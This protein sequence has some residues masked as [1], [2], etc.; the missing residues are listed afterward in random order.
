MALLVA[1]S[2]AELAQGVAHP[3]FGPSLWLSLRT[4][5]L[6]LA[7]V[8]VCGTPLAWWLASAQGWPQ[9]LADALVELPIVM[10]PAVVGIGL[11]ET[12]GRSGLLGGPLE[13]LGIQ[14][15]FATPAVILA[16]VTVSAPFYVQAAAAAF[17]RVDPDLLLVARTLGQSPV[18]AFARVAIPIAM[19]GLVSGGALAWA[20]ALGEF[21]A[22]LL[23]AGSLPGTTQTMPLAIVLALESDV[24]AAIAIS[25]VLA[26]AAV[27]LL[28]G[29]RLVAGL[30]PSDDATSR[31]KLS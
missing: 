1:A 3:L 8:V 16:Q 9:R 19:P 27:L 30:R 10:P 7:I 18:G 24:R 17:R 14:V 2:P 11:L 21:G 20:R 28:L 29:L 25:L 5:M 4:T 6:S 13:L 22:T 31:S 26:G 15:A 12:F 23:F